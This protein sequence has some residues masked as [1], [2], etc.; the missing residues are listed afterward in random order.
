MGATAGGRLVESTTVR[1]AAEGSTG[2][3]DGKGVKA[4]GCRSGVA[5]G[6][7]LATVDALASTGISGAVGT[8]PSY[9]TRQNSG[10]YSKWPL[11]IW[12]A[13]SDRF[14]PVSSLHYT[15]LQ[16]HVDIN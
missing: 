13:P 9:M 5:G 1:G 7:I 8:E 10:K 12:N 6:T 3:V 2:G 16:S 11:K 4:A 14:L 15:L